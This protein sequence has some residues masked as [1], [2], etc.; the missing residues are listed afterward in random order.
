M[1][2]ISHYL[3]VGLPGHVLIQDVHVTVIIIVTTKKCVFTVLKLNKL[4]RRF[5]HGA[6]R[7]ERPHGRDG[8]A[9]EHWVHWP[10]RRHGPQ[11]RDWAHRPVACLRR[12]C[13]CRCRGSVGGLVRAHLCAGAIAG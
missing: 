1:F 7:R 12:S 6:F 4:R 2:G 9:R 11:R 13:R 8:R 3:R 5:C 10:D